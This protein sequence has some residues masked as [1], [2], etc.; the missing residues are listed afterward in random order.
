M[1]ISFIVPVYKVEK[2]LDECVQSILNQSFN[3]YEIILVNDGS[4][5]NCPAMCV[6]YEVRYPK[7]VRVVHTKNGGPAKARNIGINIA[8]GEYLFF[9]DS[10]DFLCEDKLSELYEKAVEY[11]ADILHTGFFALNES[12]GKRIRFQPAL[13]AEKLYTHQEM[14]KQLCY[15][16]SKNII[17]FMWRNLYKR[18]FLLKNH[19]RLEEGLRM[20]EDPPFNMEAFSKAERFV[21]VD[22]PVLCYRVRENSLQRQ[23][24]VPDYDKWLYMQWGLKLKHYSENCTP[25]QVFYEDIGEYTVKSIFPMLLCNVYKNKRE[26]S[27][28]VL[29][30]IGKSEM[31]RRSF[32]DYD[33]RKFKSK[34]LDW[35]MTW[36][37]KKKMYIPAHL[38]CKY[39]LYK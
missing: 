25:S 28:K 38:M 6:G 11:N 19:I 27:F 21:A 33:I 20:V 10:D 18:E 34:S 29:K 7:K 4:P 3:D 39:I 35:L 15:S 26:E 36:F 14:E 8:K 5:D 32:K 17:T 2:Y 24:Y 22:I 1:K 30:R 9:M 12:D 23:S 13:D 31:M 16:S 37:V